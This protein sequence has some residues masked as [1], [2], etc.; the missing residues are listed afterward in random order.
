MGLYSEE[1]TLSNVPVKVNDPSIAKRNYQTF[2]LIKSSTNQYSWCLG[3]NDVPP[4]DDD[5]TLKEFL[6]DRTDIYSLGVNEVLYIK[7]SSETT[8]GKI[9]WQRI[10]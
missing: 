7:A 9:R 5:Y 2:Y 10:R 8:T 6:D 3:T 4:Q 1:I